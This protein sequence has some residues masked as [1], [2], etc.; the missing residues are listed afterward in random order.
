MQSINNAANVD[1]VKPGL[2]GFDPLPL[3][4]H[5]QGP[6]P[7]RFTVLSVEDNDD[8]RYLMS[9]TLD[10]MGYRVISCSDADSASAA[11][12]S[13]NDI[14]LLITDLE[15]PGR[16]GVELARELCELCSSLPVLVVSSAYISADLAREMKERDW[17]FLAKPYALPAFSANIH[18][19]LKTSNDQ[20]QAA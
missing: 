5:S 13:C 10:M 18:V 6:G 17:Q 1:T 8:L 7:P 15:M 16:S 19:L 12:R 2:L 9:L 3:A 14:D 4:A 11:F 20:Q